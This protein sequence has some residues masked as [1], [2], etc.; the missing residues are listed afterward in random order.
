[1]AAT[2]FAGC[3]RSWGRGAPPPPPALEPGASQADVDTALIA[4]PASLKDRQRS[5][6]NETSPTH[7]EEGHEPPGARRPVGISASAAA[8]FSASL[9]NLGRGQNM[10]PKRW[11]LRQVH[12][13]CDGERR[14]APEAFETVDVV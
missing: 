8:R 4:A 14:N 10:R 5:N 13:Q 2:T 12:A 7:A 6:G 1:M 3:R 9:S 11:G